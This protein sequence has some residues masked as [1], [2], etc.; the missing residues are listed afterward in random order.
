MPGQK[1]LQTAVW[2]LTTAAI[3]KITAALTLVH[4][5]AGALLGG[6][7]AII[8]TYFVFLFIEVFLTKQ[9]N[10]PHTAPRKNGTFHPNQQGKS[11][12]KHKTTTVDNYG[13]HQEGELR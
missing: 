9:K 12:N 13:L 2:L 8:I 6:A 3:M 4:P 5:L 7:I 10:K 11:F 1:V